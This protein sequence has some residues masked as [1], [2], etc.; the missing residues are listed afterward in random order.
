LIDIKK[1]YT[2]DRVIRMGITV[3]LFWAFISLLGFLSDVLIPFVVAVLIAYLINPLVVLVQKKVRKRTPAVL[4]SLFLVFLVFFLIALF[5]VPAIIKETR[6]MGTVVSDLVQ[7]S[8]LAK[9]A[10]EELPPDLWEALKSVI[11]SEEVQDLFK[12]EKFQNIIQTAAKKILPG[13]W[14]FISGTTSFVLGIVGFFVV[15]LYVVFLLIDY[16]RVRQGWK[17]LIP[18]DY[19][20][21]VLEFVSEFNNAMNRYF[22]GQATVA[23]IVGVLFA[24]GFWIIGVPM[25]ILLGL[26]IGVLNMVPYLQIIGFIPALI[27]ALIHALETG[28]SIWGMMGL[29]ALVFAVVQTIQDAFLTP[30]IM[31]KVTGFSPAIILLSLSIWGK[32]LGFLGLIIAL[33]MTCLILAYYKRFLASQE[34]AAGL[35][36][37]DQ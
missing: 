25:G 23:S 33:P 5:L 9:R 22:R 4:I 3:A 21:P 14:R 7:N 29:V 18:Q 2:F 10:S 8:T 35:P 17:N 30:K 26:F 32:I 24:L 36:E 27:L 28:G 20:K 1:P 12:A 11:A 19:Q 13:I 16:Q 15:F 31:G 34:R 6:H 37:E